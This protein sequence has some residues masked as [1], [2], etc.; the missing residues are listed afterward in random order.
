KRWPGKT[1]PR[2]ERGMELV[3]AVA[4]FLRSSI[5]YVLENVAGS[6]RYISK[7]FGRPAL[8]WCGR[9][10]WSDLTFPLMSPPKADWFK[11]GRRPSMREPEKREAY[12]AKLARFG[13]PDSFAGHSAMRGMI[14]TPIGEA[15]HRAV[16]DG[17]GGG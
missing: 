16:C 8:D 12:L 7:E 4:P 14:P 5:H 10:L 1:G 6:V 11:G 9:Y 3:R 17:G 13:F 2:P 15:V